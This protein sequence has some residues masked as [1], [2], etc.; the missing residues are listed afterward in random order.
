MSRTSPSDIGDDIFHSD[1]DDPE[2]E[3]RE[4]KRERERKILNNNNDTMQCTRLS[5]ENRALRLENERLKEKMLAERRLYEE[6]QGELRRE[7]QI[8]EANLELLEVMK[9]HELERSL[10]ALK[11]DLEEKVGELRRN[12]D[13]IQELNK[14]VRQERKNA[15][16]LRGLVVE[17][18][19]AG[20]SVKSDD[21]QVKGKHHHTIIDNLRILPRICGKFLPKLSDIRC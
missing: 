7:N 8:L 2:E 6:Y 18:M 4:M 10:Q 1:D 14:M 9:S 3:E 21:K 5:E 16:V 12:K 13:T 11:S 17:G 15:A 20:N 19:I